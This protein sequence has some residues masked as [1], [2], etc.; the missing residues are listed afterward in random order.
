MQSLNK[1]LFGRLLN[2]GFI[3]R[4]LLSC[5]LLSVAIQSPVLANTP[6][7]SP[8]SHDQIAS[9]TLFSSFDQSPKHLDP[10]VSYSSNEWS[11]LGQIYEPP[12]QYHYLKRPYTLEPLTLREMPK[13]RYLDKDAQPVDAQF[14]AIAYSEYTFS[15]KP[16]VLYQ[17]H[18]AFAQDA[19]GEALYFNLDPATLNSLNNLNDL[20]QGAQRQLRSDDY[21]YAIKRMA[22]RQ[23]HSPILDSMTQYIV[24]L[25]E[26]S[27]SVTA[28]YQT[29]LDIQKQHAGEGESL[30]A[31]VSYFDLNK[32]SISGVQAIDS[33][34]FKIT[35]KGKYPQF[36]YWLSMNFFAPIPWEVDRFYKQPG[37]VKKNITLDTSPVGTG[38]YQLVENNPNKQMRLLKNPN[39]RADFYPVDGLPSDANPNLLAD[40]GKPIPFI[41]EVIYSL[42]KESVPLWNKFLQGYYDASGLSS[43]SFDQAISVSSSGSMSLTPEMAEKGIQFLNVI[44]PSTLYFGFNMADEQVGGYS[45]QQQKLRQAISIALNFE[46]YISI[47][48]NG[49]GV[50]AQSPIPPGIFGFNEGQAGIN[51]WVYDWLEQRPQ[52]KSIDVAKALLAEAGYPNGRLPNGEPLVLH[53]DTAATGP[54]SQSLLNWYR[55]QFAA[56]GIQLVIRATNYNRFQDKVRGAKVQM[57]S[58]G[59]NAD[60]PDP[61]NFLFLLAGKNAAINTNGAGINSSNY[62]NPKFNALFAQVQ[63]MD[64]TPER[65]ALIDKMVHIAQ[66]D[67]PWAW[68]YHPQSLALYH[69][70]YHNVWA[71]PLANNTLKYKRIEPEQRKVLQNEWNQVVTWPFWLLL[72]VIIGAIYP[73][74]KAYVKRQNATL[75]LAS[76][77]AINTVATSTSS[78]D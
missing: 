32:H 4:V 5:G 9:K 15:L 18:P 55:K 27:K 6:W 28:L 8:Y 29:Q 78:K 58:W 2:R 17:P 66:Q 72:L 49:R 76:P 42:E 24:G 3:G 75:L 19:Q 12:L 47:F 73:L 59:W 1:S 39:Y 64:N 25:E 62:D 60:Y 21:V 22:L 54:D 65:Q 13:V 45:P 71:N 40:A 74:R 56:L 46:E 48:M 7:N 10:V 51:P 50:A 70:W 30:G 31:K 41:D 53:Y 35:I 67:S 36:L 11:I 44:Q 23:N 52:R 68:G 34:S 69:S 37:L 57:F 14:E 61:E 77:L 26:F 33:H 16:G 63:N 43:D 38:P 20:Q